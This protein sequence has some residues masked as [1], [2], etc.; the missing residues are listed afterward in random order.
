MGGLHLLRIGYENILLKTSVNLWGDYQTM[1]ISGDVVEQAEQ[2]LEFIR[3][4]D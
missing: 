1:S 2:C 3:I 4:A